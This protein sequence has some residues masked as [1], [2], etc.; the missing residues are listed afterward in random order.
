MLARDEIDVNKATRE[1]GPTPLYMACQ[2]GHADIVKLLFA[3][4]EIDVNKARSDIGATPFYIAYNS[5]QLTPHVNKVNEMNDSI[6]LI[7]H[8]RPGRQAGRRG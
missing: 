4:D 8:I 1:D 7:K 2:E 3:C 5:S 6:S